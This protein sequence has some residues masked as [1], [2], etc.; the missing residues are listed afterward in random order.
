[1][2]DGS[3]PLDRGAGHADAAAAHALLDSGTAPDTAGAAG[4]TNKNV[5]VNILQGAGVPTFTDVVTRSVTGLKPGQRFETYYKVPSNTSAIVLTLS[6]VTPGDNQN[7]LLGDN[8]LLAIHSAK[9]SA[10]GDY[11]VLEF[12][13][14]GTWTISDPDAGLMRVT[15]NGNWTNASPI[16]ATVT[17]VPQIAASPGQTVQASVLDGE[18]RVYPFTVPPGAASL[19]VRLE[20]DGHWGMYPSNDL[21]LILI[22]PSGPVN[23]DGATAN[24]PERAAVANP[25]AGQWIAVVDGFSIATK[26]GDKF[27]LRVAIDG[28]VVK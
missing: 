26:N 18:T 17:I 19:S 4:G 14:G 22:P 13:S 15:L 24:A 7:V 11:N 5:S 16:G 28:T 9:T 10:F 12:T 2:V 25:V 23:V 20:W 27:S 21:D 6:G 1:M 3:G 8:I